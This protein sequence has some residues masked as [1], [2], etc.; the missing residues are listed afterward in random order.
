MADMSAITDNRLL[1]NFTFVK[2]SN[3]KQTFLRDVIKLCDNEYKKNCRRLR[4]I[5]NNYKKLVIN[6]NPRNKKYIF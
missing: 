2:L 4:K 1:K 5:L 3:C 6:G